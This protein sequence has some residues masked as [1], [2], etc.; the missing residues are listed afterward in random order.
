MQLKPF[1]RL[2][3]DAALQRLT[4]CIAFTIRAWSRRTSQWTARQSMAHQSTSRWVTAPAGVPAVI[5]IVSLIGLPSSLVKKDHDG[6]LPAFAWGDLVRVNSTPI[7]LITRR[8]SL[9]PSSYARTPIGFPYGSLSLTGE[10]RVY[11]VPRSN[12]RMG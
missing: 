7:R 11:H 2:F 1:K 10:V 9:F 5:C 3:Q 12:H 8:P 4:S 6:S